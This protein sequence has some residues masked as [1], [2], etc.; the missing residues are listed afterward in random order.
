MAVNN[1]TMEQ[2]EYTFLFEKLPNN[3]PYRDATG[4]GRVTVKQLPWCFIRFADDGED[5]KYVQPLSPIQMMC[6]GGGHQS[7]LRDL[8]FAETVSVCSTHGVS[9]MEFAEFAPFPYERYAR[10]PSDDRVG[11]PIA[12]HF[13]GGI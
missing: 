1:N 11:G 5:R 8:T 12:I 7:Q 3:A 6:G 4:Y 10:V 13:F 9:F 2:A